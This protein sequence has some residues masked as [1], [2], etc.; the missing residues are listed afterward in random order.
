MV[1]ELPKYRPPIPN[2]GADTPEH[3]Q[4]LTALAGL[5]ERLR[6]LTR[7][8]VVTREAIVA[9]WPFDA[10]PLRSAEHNDDQDQWTTATIAAYV[11]RLEKRFR[12]GPADPTLAS[13]AREAIM[14]LPADLAADTLGEIAAAGIDPDN[15]RTRDIAEIGEIL[16]A[17][18]GLVAAREQLVAMWVS[19]APAIAEG[20]LEYLRDRLG[21]PDHLPGDI[22]RPL[23]GGDLVMFEAL[24]S[25]YTARPDGST[26]EGRVADLVAACGGRSPAVTRA[27]GVAA[28]YGFGRPKSTEAIAD[29]PAFTALVLHLTKLA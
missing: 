6:A 22:V 27:K 25:F 19:S 12:M 2:S 7:R 29:D 10:P 21:M 15:M 1:V 17:K 8:G 26:V 4:L 28:E 14:T 20:A 9:H 5:R 16:I 18:D 11:D 24:C 13:A 23:T 3:V